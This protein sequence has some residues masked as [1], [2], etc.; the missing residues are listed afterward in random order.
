MADLIHLA[1]P[2]FEQSGWLAP[3]LLILISSLAL[4]RNPYP[5][6]FLLAVF[7][8][9]W[10]LLALRDVLTQSV[11]LTMFAIVGM[12]VSVRW[13]PALFRAM[14]DISAVTYF[15]AAL[16]KVNE[17]FLE[18]ELSCAVH[19]LEQLGAHWNLWVPATFEQIAPVTAIVLELTLAVC[20]LRRSRWFWVFALIFHLPLMV[21]LAPA[22]GLVMMCGAIASIRR[23]EVVNLRRL[24][25][26]HRRK[27]VSV[28]VLS[29]ALEFLLGVGWLNWTQPPQVGLYVV[30]CASLFL[31]MYPKL[32]STYRNYWL[33]TI[34]FIF[35]LTPYLGIQVQHTAA[36][37]S[38][39]RIDNGC[40]NSLIF[41]EALVGKDTYVR[42][43][44]AKFGTDRWGKR[45]EILEDGLWNEAALFTM[46]RKWCVEWVR[47]IALTMQYRG[48]T[49]EIDDLCSE[50]SLN[51]FPSFFQTLPQYQRFQKNLTRNCHQACIH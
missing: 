21:T 48:K 14:A 10:T 17:N 1:L 33:P 25:S 3:G 4:L 38:N 47:P 5:L 46:R 39:L 29:F 12:L 19:A 22:F 37:L 27:L 23:R 44:S 41:S 31:C 26:R 30:G 8:H 11:L 36:M 45:V 51:F 6:A 7:A 42:I 16:H 49:I 18:P 28:F 20:L 43:S 2:D 40:H 35:C 13:Q 34:W 15:A 9:A 50:G 32:K 24:W